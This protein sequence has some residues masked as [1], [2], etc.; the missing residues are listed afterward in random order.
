MGYPVGWGTNATNE[1]NFANNYPL[2]RLFTVGEFNSSTTPYSDLQ[3]V[4]QPWAVASDDSIYGNRKKYFSSV[5]WFFGRHIFDKLV[6]D[7]DAVPIGLISSNWG[8]TGIERWSPPEAL[9]TC[10]SKG[11]GD[12]YNS[13]IHPFAFG[14][15]SLTGFTWYQGEKNTGSL[16]SAQQYSCQQDAL[17]SAWRRRFHNEQ[18]FFGFV[19]LST[20]CGGAGLVQGLPEFREAQ[21]Q[22][23]KLPNVGYATNADHGAG[24]YIHPPAK[25]FCGKRLADSALALTYKKSLPWRS[26]SYL[27][28]SASIAGDLVAVEVTLA[29]VG[30][31]G[32]T[33]DVYPANYATLPEGKIHYDPPDCTQLNSVT[34]GTCAWAAI[35][36][37]NL[38]WVNATVAPS[39]G[40]DGLT[41]S[42]KAEGVRN[43]DEILGNA[44]AWGPIPLMNAYDK[45][46]ALPVLPWNRS[47]SSSALV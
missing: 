3:Y 6:V 39:A 8:N 29:D 27:S 23:L 24:C 34:P 16:A 26:P 7:G 33:I 35:H 2:I 43:V 44:Y 11:N 9:E 47:L 15:L 37:A 10:D 25:Q 31:Q 12:L 28:S 42:V 19:Q 21:L 14:P 30:E 1:M 17:I 36:L 46:S 5:C 4:L 38:G 41:L 18:A 40:G 22:S 20:W 45:G 13:M 32:L